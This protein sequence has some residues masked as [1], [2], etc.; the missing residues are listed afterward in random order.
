MLDIEYYNCNNKKCL[1]TIDLSNLESSKKEQDS[2]FICL[3]DRSGSMD[4]N[5]YI[6]VKEI[7]PRVLQN[8]KY[9][10]KQNILITYDDEA[11]KYVG[12]AE[13]FKSQSIE[14]RG[15]NQLYLGLTELEK[16]FDEYI[17][18]NKNLPI[19]LLTI[20]DGDIGSENELYKKINEL[21]PKITNKLIVNSHAVRYFTSSSPPETKGLSSILKLNN[22][23][24]GKLIDIN[25]T[26]DNEK[27]AKKISDLFLADGLDEI[28]KI[29]SEQKNLYDNPWGD[30]SF[31]ILLKKGKIFYG[32]KKWIIFK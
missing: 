8:L 17:K 21:I 2:I 30:P 22:I 14:C 12:D 15:D 4:N 23:T 24:V 5:V 6:F 13:Y 10:K 9:E 31:E 7:F 18:S 28:Y 26:D 19:R 20:S 3:L 16:I 11:I 25:A 32:V 27:N 29:T 1:M